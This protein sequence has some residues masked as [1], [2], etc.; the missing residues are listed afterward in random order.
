LNAGPGRILRALATL[1]VRGEAAP[2]VRGDLEEALRR[3]VSRGMSLRRARARYLRN[4]LASAWNLARSPLEAVP[5][6]VGRSLGE[7]VT[8]LELAIRSITRHARFTLLTIVTLAPGLGAAAA[9][10]GM[11]DQ[12]L[13]RPLPGV[14]DEDRGAYLQLRRP[15]RPE[16]AGQGF[17]FPTLYLEDVSRAASAV[18]GMALYGS[19]SVNV[20]MG[21]ARPLGGTANVIYGDFFGVL[22]VRPSEGRLLRA[23]ETGPDSPLVAVISQ[24]LRAALFDPNAEPV[25][26]TVR[27]NGQDVVLIGVAGG[28]FAGPERGSLVDIWLPYSSLSTVFAQSYIDLRSHSTVALSDIVLRV[29]NGASFEAAESQIRQV[30]RDLPTEDPQVGIYLNRMTPTLIPGLTSPPSWRARIL[31]TLR[32]LS[33]VVLLILLISCANMANLVLLKNARRRSEIA[34]RR[35]L[36]ASGRRIAV[37]H[38]FETLILVGLGTLAG[39]AFAWLATLPFEGESLDLLPAFERFTIDGRVL[40]FGGALTVLVTALVGTVPA[41]IASRAHPR[42]ALGESRGL[43]TGRLGVVRQVVSAFQF[44]LCLTLLVGG[45]LMIRTVQNLYAIENPLASEDIWEINLGGSAGATAPAL[46]T[47]PRW[48]AFYEGLL[49]DAAR[50]PGVR[51]QALDVYGVDADPALGRIAESPEDAWTPASALPVTAGWFDLMGVSRT[52]GG[53]ALGADWDSGTRNELLVTSSL[54]TRLFGSTDVVGR[55]VRAQAGPD[56]ETFQIIGVTTDIRG[57][58]APDGPLDAYFV[59]FGLLPRRSMR[60]LVQAS[61]F[62]VNVA[63]ELRRVAEAAL[64]GQPVP[65]PVPLRQRMDRLHAEQRIFARLLGALAGIG[66]LLAVAGLYAV[67]SFS[68]SSRR[69]EFGIRLSLGAEGSHIRGLLLRNLAII[70]G[71]GVG[72]GTWGAW[73]ISKA[74]SHRLFGVTPLEPGVYAAAIATLVLTACVACWLPIRAAVRVDP[75]DT[76]RTT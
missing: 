36:G 32:L 7:L 8:D 53:A 54:A 44:A 26:R 22:G 50:V 73:L 70:L 17:A 24:R 47:G 25:G 75:V 31:A 16:G 3:D 65:D 6:A 1:L 5:A 38:L 18:D 46:P 63:A 29:R 66:L 56:A 52:D 69:R 60:L 13:L 9:I 58:S 71:L 19:R 74:L 33:G 55:S 4:L 35:A 49:N 2:F 59:P 40:L 30:I 64:P 27:V 45:L 21:D 76:L 62:D 61:P 68:V 51:A 14:N 34:T 48:R 72:A 57:V 39:L 11:L 23:N 37:Q 43:E 12:L 28:G 15:D 42:A 10:F 41:L 67:I 20:G